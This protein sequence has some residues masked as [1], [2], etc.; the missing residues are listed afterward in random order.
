ML[1]HDDDL[2]YDDDDEDGTT[3]GPGQYFNPH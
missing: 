2:Y 1:G 3:P